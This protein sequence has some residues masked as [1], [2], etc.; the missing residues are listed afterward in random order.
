VN[1]AARIE[2][3]AARLGASL[4][5][6]AEVVAAAPGMDGE[7]HLVALSPRLPRGRSQ[8]VRLFRP[9]S[10]TVAEDEDLMSLEAPLPGQPAPGSARGPP[11]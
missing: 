3:E 11:A 4:L 1:T 8:P 7:L 10:D 6:S 9:K 5:I 2:A